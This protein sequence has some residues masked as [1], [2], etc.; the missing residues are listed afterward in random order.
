[1]LHNVHWDSVGSGD[2][3]VLRQVGNDSVPRSSCPLAAAPTM[4]L[5]LS[6]PAFVHFLI[7]VTKHPRKGN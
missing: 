3:V 7:G 5:D 2:S 6:P 4:P 1:M